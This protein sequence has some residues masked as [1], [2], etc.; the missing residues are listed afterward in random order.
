[1]NFT[2]YSKNYYSIADILVTQEKIPCS[3]EMDLCGMG[4]LDSTFDHPNV[5]AGEKL[6]LPLWYA[7]ECKAQR[8]RTLKF[9]VP[10]IFKSR[11][12]D[13]CEA[14]ALAVDLGRLNKYFY[15][16]GH[17]IA[18]Y[19]RSGTVAP[20]LYETCRARCRS[21][22][23]LSKDISRELKNSQKF[24]FIESELYLVGC[25]TNEAFTKWLRGRSSLLETPFMVTNHKK[26]QRAQLD[27]TYDDNPRLSKSPRI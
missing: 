8:T 3:A 1:M 17:Y 4:E 14:D 15:S 13:I 5:A 27:G 25:Q 6:E 20:M 23:D 18:P 11:L 9:Q 7:I 21:L 2:S 12:K 22:I 10:D 19:D 24:E 26:R 16:F